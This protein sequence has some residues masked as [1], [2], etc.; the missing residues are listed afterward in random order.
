MESHALNN[1]LT[2]LPLSSNILSNE[3]CLII[4]P[5]KLIVYVSNEGVL[6]SCDLHMKLDS[7]HVYC[8]IV[9]I[10]ET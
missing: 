3:Q 5:R 7:N 8:D 1:L 9:C 10:I 4:N 2:L 6:V